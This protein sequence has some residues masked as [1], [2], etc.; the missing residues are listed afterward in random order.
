MLLYK[1]PP[2][3]NVVASSTAVLPNLPTGMTYV[4][5]V[6]KRGGTFT[7]AQLSNIR[8]RLDGKQF[9]D[10]T[11]PHL[12]AHH[13]YN[14][15]SAVNNLGSHVHVENTGAS[16]TQNADTAAPTAYAGAYDFIPYGDLQ[17]RSIGGEMA[18]AIDTSIGYKSFEMEVDIGAA[19]SP[20]LE[21]W[22]LV[23]PPKPADDPN[24]RTISTL[25]KATHSPAAAGEFSQPIPLGTRGGALI[26]KVYF[27][28]ANMT[29]LQVSKDGLWLVQE[30]E[31]ALLDFV[32]GLRNK[33][34]QSGLIVFDPT[35]NNN[36]GETI[37][38]LRPDANPAVFEFKLTVSGSDTISSYSRLLT[39]LDR[40]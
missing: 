10:V 40:V 7:N 3:Q 31:Q 35:F 24:K 15:L 37:S 26:D 23:A 28:H 30:G 32:Q 9:I 11:G 16:Y 33:T 21:S 2:F 14:N 38:T 17:A 29:K 12:R 6:L 4:G 20:T 1:L 34:N 5:I 25:L 39:T 19:T 22:A 36:N 27:H 18:G 8:Q 13:Q